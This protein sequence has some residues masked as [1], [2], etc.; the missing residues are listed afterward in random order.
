MGSGAGGSAS[1]EQQFGQYATKAEQLTGIP[2]QLILAQWKIESASGSSYGARNRRNLAGIGGLGNYRTYP[3]F[4]AFVVDYANLMNKSYPQVAKAASSGGPQAAAVALGN[5][6]WAEHKYRL[7]ATGKEGNYAGRPGTEGMA[8]IQAMG[9]KTPSNPSASGPASGKSAA[10]PASTP[11]QV[12]F[13]EA[14]TPIMVPVT[15]NEADLTALAMGLVPD[16]PINFPNSSETQQKLREV[17]D[18]RIARIRDQIN[19]QFGN[20]KQMSTGVTSQILAA[21]SGLGADTTLAGLDATSNAYL[22]SLA[23]VQQ[24]KNVSSAEDDYAKAMATLLNEEFQ[25]RAAYS[26]GI[27]GS[28]VSALNAY[29]DIEKEKGAGYRFNAG[30]YNTAAQS[31]YNNEYSTAQKLLDDQLQRQRSAATQMWG[32]QKQYMGLGQSQTE[33]QKSA[34]DGSIVVADVEDAVIG[35]KPANGSSNTAVLDTAINT[36]QKK[37]TFGASDFVRELAY[38]A[39][40]SRAGDNSDLINPSE[41]IRYINNYANKFG[42]TTTSTSEG[43]SGTTTRTAVNAKG[44]A[45]QMIAEYKSYT[46]WGKDPVIRDE[47]RTRWLLAAAG[48]LSEDVSK[49]PADAS[50]TVTSS[51]K[52]SWWDIGSESIATGG[53]TGGA[54]AVAGLSAAP[55]AIATAAPIIAMVMAFSGSFK[56][57][58]DFLEKINDH[59]PSWMKH[60]KSPQAKATPNAI[61][62]L[63]SNLINPAKGGEIYNNLMRNPESIQKQI[64][65]YPELQAA[66]TVGAHYA[67]A[68]TGRYSQEA[69]KLP[70]FNDAAETLKKTYG[71]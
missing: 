48:A 12:A 58:W 61:N 19:T 34:K 26:V 50:R 52:K 17:A 2:A 67:L 5:S 20:A 37:A 66:L 65:L 43:P 18:Q 25:K 24:V 38:A 68:A 69:S 56:T 8:L 54:A 33:A 62:I 23:G 64:E 11:S 9:L 39:Y 45:D 10:N 57:T 16:S 3:S 30:A 41:A 60:K 32:L 46:A 35:F 53:V 6:K 51:K 40:F 59:L 7:G 1:F 14:P 63:I 21:G 44:L 42:P 29:A 70:S 47:V 28:R 15:I 55:G 4:D 36:P 22:K 49:V 13:P 27:P 71:V 31:K